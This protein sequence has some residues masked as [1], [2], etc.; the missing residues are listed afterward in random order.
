MAGEITDAEVNFNEEHSKLRQECER[1]FALLKGRF[2]R[3]R[4]VVT[5]DPEK[6]GRIT[7]ACAVLHN[8]AIKKGDISLEEFTDKNPPPRPLPPLH[9]RGASSDVHGMNKRDAI[10]TALARRKGIPV[11]VSTLL[12]LHFRKV[13]AMQVS[14]MF[15]MFLIHFIFSCY[16]Q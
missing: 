5:A 16:F 7:A 9:I 4:Y 13:H 6:A 12:S 8:F 2:K 1:A 11:N 14:A 10:M 15:L 3:L